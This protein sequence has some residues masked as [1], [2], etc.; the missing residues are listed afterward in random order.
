MAQAS[1]FALFSQYL[2]AHVALAKSKAAYGDGVVT[3]RAESIELKST[4][5]IHQEPG[6][7][8]HSVAHHPN[9]ERL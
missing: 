7:G 4:K 1:I 8:A 2:D 6:T 3:L 5:L 9:V